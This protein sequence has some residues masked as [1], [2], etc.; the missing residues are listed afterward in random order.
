[1]EEWPIGDGYCDV[2]YDVIYQPDKIACLFW[3]EQIQSWDNKHSF[4]SGINT[5]TNHPCWRRSVI[6]HPWK[7]DRGPHHNEYID[8]LVQD[9]SNSSASAMEL[10]QS[11]AEPSILSHSVISKHSKRPAVAIDIVIS[12]VTS[13]VRYNSTLMTSK[14]WYV[15]YLHVCWPIRRIGIEHGIK[16]HT[17][18]LCGCNYLFISLID[19]I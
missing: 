17:T 4:K 3:S 9:C 16:F 8:G 19:G 7:I 11:C 14:V 12:P 13:T 10:L 15:S 1:M 18:V 2:R 6:I 5:W